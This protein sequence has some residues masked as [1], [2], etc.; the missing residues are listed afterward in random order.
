MFTAS[1]NK[2]EYEALLA[3]LKLAKEL[4]IKHLTVNCDSLL[5]VQQETDRRSPYT[6]YLL[7]GT[8]PENIADRRP[9]AALATGSEFLNFQNR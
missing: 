7:S 9:A 2:A 1:N 5:V 4:H 6:Q 8:V 3:R